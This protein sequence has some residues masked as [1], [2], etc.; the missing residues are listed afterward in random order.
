MDL[1][2][3]TA[4]RTCVSFLFSSQRIPVMSAAAEIDRLRWC[5]VSLSV[6]VS[7]TEFREWTQ[8]AFQSAVRTS[9]F[10]AAGPRWGSTQSIK[11]HSHW[12]QRLGNRIS[13][14]IWSCKRNRSTFTS[15][16]VLLFSSEKEKV[17]LKVIRLL[18]FGGRE[19]RGVS[20]N[21]ALASRGCN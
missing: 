13:M 4:P 7:R 21:L 19:C 5:G 9:R 18:L 3:P 15:I 6:W 1:P 20:W 11:E 14:L 2:F 17:A 12:Q 10:R 16:C 8:L